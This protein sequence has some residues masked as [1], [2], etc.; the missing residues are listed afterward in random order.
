ME[1]V[2]SLEA[3][4]AESVRGLTLCWLAVAILRSCF[5]AVEEP[6]C[7]RRRNVCKGFWSRLTPDNSTEPTSLGIADWESQT[8][9]R[10]LGVARHLPIPHPGI[11]F[12]QT[13]LRVLLLNCAVLEGRGLFG[14]VGVRRDKCER[15]TGGEKI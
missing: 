2:D 15:E 1:V 8:G 6:R 7:W 12:Y 4:K 3:H 10:R 11:C 13:T 14:M 5:H 9:N